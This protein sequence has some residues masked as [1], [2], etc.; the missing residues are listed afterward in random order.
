MTEPNILWYTYFEK[1]LSF[2]FKNETNIAWNRCTTELSYYDIYMLPKRNYPIL[3]HLI[4]GN[5]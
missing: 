4:F 5:H 2:G 3:Q 1:P